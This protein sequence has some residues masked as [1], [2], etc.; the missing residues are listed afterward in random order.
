[1]YVRVYIHI[2]KHTHTFMKVSGM[3]SISIQ[4]LHMYMM[5][6]GSSVTILLPGSRSPPKALT[7]MSI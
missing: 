4:I 5:R 3:P 2:Y 7:V 1:M 6:H